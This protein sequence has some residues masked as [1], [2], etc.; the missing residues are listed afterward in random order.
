MRPSR[1]NRPLRLPQRK[2][3]CPAPSPSPTIWAT[4]SPWTTPSGSW[5]AWQFRERLGAGRGHARGRFR[6]CAHG[7]RLDIESPDVATVGDFTAV[8]LEAIMA[9]NPDFVIMTSGTGGRGGDSSQIDLRDAAC[10][11][12]HSRGLLRGDHLRRLRAPHARLHRHHRACGSLR[13]ERG[14][15]GPRP[16][17]PLWARC[18]G[19]EPADGAFAHHLL[20]RHSRAEL[21]APRPGPCWPISG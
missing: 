12:G 7:C 17:T 19:R 10:G 5:H 15:G 9:L 4:R 14:E 8:N 13:S 6:R 16:S 3:R 18:P 20:R 1:S 2:Q 11:R 21:R